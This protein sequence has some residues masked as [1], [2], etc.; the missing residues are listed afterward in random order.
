M[1]NGLAVNGK[2]EW[3]IDT[4]LRDVVLRSVTPQ[5]VTPQEHRPLFSRCTPKN[6]NARTAYV[7]IEEKSYKIGVFIDMNRKVKILLTTFRFIVFL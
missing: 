7:S 5:P 3:K 1:T 4:R 2:T 6:H